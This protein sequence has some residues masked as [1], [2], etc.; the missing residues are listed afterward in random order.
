MPD[1][2]IIHNK[3]RRLYQKPYKLL[4][5]GKAPSDDCARVV[6]KKL[7]Q[8][9]KEKGDVPVKLC[10]GM[11]DILIQSTSEGSVFGAR[12]Y[13]DL[14]IKFDKLAEQSDGRPDLKRLAL[15][16]GKSILHDLR[17]GRTQQIDF[18]NIQRL[19]CE[20]YIRGVYVSEFKERIPLTNEHHGGIDQVTLSRRIEGIQP[21]VDR[22]ISKFARDMVNKQSVSSLSL[23]SRSSIKAIDLDEDLLA[24]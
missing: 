11:A 12:E 13:A 3:L 18:G 1:G 15:D 7:K 17:Y 16:A 19:M 5:E 10:Q 6:L 2:D 9:V 22:G 4:C 24:G 8:D 23:P 20:R 14:S 21:V